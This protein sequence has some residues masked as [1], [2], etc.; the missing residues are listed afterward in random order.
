MEGEKGDGGYW[1]TTFGVNPAKELSPA[2][3]VLEEYVQFLSP[4]RWPHALD[5]FASDCAGKPGDSPYYKGH[6][7]FINMC[8][9]FV[10]ASES[11]ADFLLQQQAKKTYGP[12][13]HVTR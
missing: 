10:A 1:K 4:V 8:Y 2:R 6:Y 3:R 13:F 7:Y 12:R 11:I 5:L 9:S